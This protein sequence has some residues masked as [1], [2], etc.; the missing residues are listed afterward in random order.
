MNNIIISVKRFL[1]NKNV[2]TVLGVLLIMAILYIFYNM[3]I[4]QQ[5]APVQVPVAKQT[6]QPRTLITNDMIQYISVPAVGVNSKVLRSRSA[7]VGKYT[8]YNTVIPEGSMFYEDVVVDADDLPDSSFTQVKEGDVPFNF[9]VDM[10]STYGNSIFPGNKIDIYMKAENDAGQV[11][12]G[13]L[14]ENIEVLAVKDRNGKDVFEDTSEDRTPAFLIFWVSE[15]INILLRKAQY[16]NDYSVI[17]F[18]VPHGGTVDTSGSTQVST[19]YL[20]EFIESKTV[21]IPIEGD[22]NNNNN[23]EENNPIEGE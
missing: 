14:I 21:N 6:I 18:P 20:K 7:I 5:V 16:M 15:E 4:N 8:D 22:N 1:K 3:Q 9:A 10:D 11:M 17:L 23:N 12:V 19:Q 13:K 2:V